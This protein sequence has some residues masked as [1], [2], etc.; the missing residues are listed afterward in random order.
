MEFVVPVKNI[1]KL[2]DF[3][4]QKSIDIQIKSHLEGAVLLE[5]CEKYYKFE[6]SQVYLEESS[7]NQKKFYISKNRSFVIIFKDGLWLGIIQ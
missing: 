6:I 1:N 5:K 7:Y 3:P 4:T 2:V